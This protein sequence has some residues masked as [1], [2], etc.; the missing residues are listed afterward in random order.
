MEG[1][2]FVL[3]VLLEQCTFQD[4][5]GGMP[6]LLVDNT[7]IYATESMV[8]EFYSDDTTLQVCVLEDDRTTSTTTEPACNRTVPVKGLGTI[9]SPFLSKS[10]PVFVSFQQV[11]LP[12]DFKRFFSSSCTAFSSNIVQHA[13]HSVSVV[14]EFFSGPLPVV[15]VLPCTTCST[16]FVLQNEQSTDLLC[17]FPFLY[18]CDHTMHR[19]CLSVLASFITYSNLLFL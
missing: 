16:F 2:D 17:A 3:Q 9:S 15:T 4:N 11:G 12:L 7:G 18:S 14:Y 10:D 6:N 13:T 19:I 1:V 5:T 8:P